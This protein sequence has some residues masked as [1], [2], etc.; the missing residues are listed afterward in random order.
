MLPLLEPLT[1][2]VRTALQLVQVKLTSNRVPNFPIE[3]RI[4]TLSE[5]IIQLGHFSD[6]FSKLGHF[7]DPFSKLG[8][9]CYPN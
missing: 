7:S 4:Y 8:T 3:V 2:Q 6:P 5:A 1:V 9:N